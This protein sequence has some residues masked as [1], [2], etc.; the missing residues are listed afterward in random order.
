MNRGAV[1][2]EEER[3]KLFPRQ[4]YW[5]P[6]EVQTSYSPCYFCSKHVNDM[7][8]WSPVSLHLEEDFSFFCEKYCQLILWKNLRA[9]ERKASCCRFWSQ[10]H[11]AAGCT[12]WTLTG[13]LTLHQQ[14]WQWKSFLVSLIPGFKFFFSSFFFFELAGR[15]GRRRE[16]EELDFETA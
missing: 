15:N 13:L 14:V 5:S 2:V 4:Q 12:S 16:V 1:W 10:H 11:I 6:H 8:E 9:G 3:G 7:A